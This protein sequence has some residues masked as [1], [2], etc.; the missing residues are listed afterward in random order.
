MAD[1]KAFIEALKTY[2]KDSIPEKILKKLKKQYIS[3]PNF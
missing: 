1:P 3:D 2:K